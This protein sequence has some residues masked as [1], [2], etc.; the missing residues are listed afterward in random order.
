MA[1]TYNQGS[2]NPRAKLTARQVHE[3]RTNTRASSRLLGLRYGV[4][5]VA[6]LKIKNNK[7]YTQE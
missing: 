4:S 2:N 5:H 7:S 3:I 1:N 6:I